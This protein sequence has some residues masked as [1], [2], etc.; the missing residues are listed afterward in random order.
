MGDFSLRAFFDVVWK[1]F[2]LPFQA[3]FTRCFL[4]IVSKCQGFIIA[5][6]LLGLAP[7]VQMSIMFIDFHNKPTMDNPQHL[8]RTPNPST[9]FVSTH[10]HN[11]IYVIY[12][13]HLHVY[14]IYL[15]LNFMEFYF[16]IIIL[17]NIYI[18]L[19]YF[20]RSVFHMIYHLSIFV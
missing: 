15:I 13:Y 17:T 9:P 3:V 2:L 1:V 5:V 6:S 8:I 14:S 20:L 16:F 19:F 12:V 7:S 10:Y 18:C 11:I 4:Y